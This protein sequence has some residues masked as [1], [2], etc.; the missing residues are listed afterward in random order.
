MFGKACHLL[1]E[2]EQRAMWAIKQLNFDLQSAGLHRKLQLSELEEM[3]NE[4]YDSSR[5]Y[6]ERMKAFHDKHI[7]KKSFE[8]GMKFWLFNSR[9]KLFPGKLRSRWNGP[10]IV[11]KIFHHGAIQIQDPRTNNMFTVNGQRFKPYI[12]GLEENIQNG[13]TIEEVTLVDPVYEK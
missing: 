13:A 2:L 10:Y 8:L 12:E 3:R 7:V 5:V 4:A 1:V 6:N 11:T 9:L